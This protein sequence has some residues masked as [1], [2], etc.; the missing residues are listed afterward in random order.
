MAHIQ[1]TD[2]KIQP[3][4]SYIHVD[5]A[6]RQ[7]D[8]TNHY[9]E[10]LYSLPPYALHF[11]NNSS[12]VT[13][14][15]PGH[16]FKNGDHI[17]LNN[18]I[19]KNIILNNVLSVKK[20]SFFVRILHKNHG[21]SLHSLYNPNSS[22]E[23]DLIEY[24][25]ELPMS[26]EENDDIPDNLN[27]HYILKKNH[28]LD[29]TI[30][31]SN[32]IGSNFNR[33]FIGNISVNYLNKKQIVYLIFTKRNNIFQHDPDSYLIMLDKR[34]SINYK[35]GTNFLK[36]RSE[37]PTNILANNNIYIKFFNLFGIPLN[38]LNS[39]TPTNEN[40][41]YAYMTIVSTS[42]NSFTIDAN[43]NAIVDP[44]NSFYD[45]SDI[46]DQNININD[47]IGSNKGGGNKLFAR[48]IYITSSGY[49]DPNFYCFKLDRTYKNIFQIKMISSI[50]PNSQL[51]I[52]NKTSDIA[53]NKL[54]WRNLDDGDYIYSLSVQ[55]GNY[56]P[57]QLSNEIEKKFSKI[58]RYPYTKE[59]ESEIYQPFLDHLTPN[60]NMLYDEKGYNKFH[61]VKINI[62]EKTDKVLFRAFRELV[63][64]GQDGDVLNIPDNKI[65]ITVTDNLPTSANEILYMYI[66]P[67]THITS[68][69]AELPY[70]YNNLYKYI[71]Q[72]TRHDTFIADLDTDTAVLV[73]FYHT[74]D[75]NSEPVHELN[76]INTSSVLENFNYNYLDHLLGEVT[77]INHNLKNGDLVITDQFH[78]PGSINKI[79]VYE[80][81]EIVSADKFLVRRYDYGEKYKFIYGGTI[82]NFIKKDTPIPIP[83]PMLVSI[84]PTGAKKIMVVKHPNHQL[85]ENDVIT[86]SNSS[87]MNRVPAHIINKSYPINK[88]LD[89]N[90]YEILL[91]TYTPLENFVKKHTNMCNKISIK[92]PDKFQLL[93]NYGDTLGNIIGFSSVGENSSVTP[94]KHKIYNSDPYVSG[95]QEKNKLTK[96]NMTGYNYFYISCPELELYHNTKPV[97]NVFSVVRWFD[98]PGNVV[99][100]SFEPSTKIFRTP[101][102]F[103]FELN[104]AFYH[105][106]GRL[107][108]FNGLDHS[109]TLEI[110]E[111]YPIN[112]S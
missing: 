14:N 16:K 92:Y 110:T 8:H 22:E 70:T 19:S 72:R 90:H 10:E 15:L 4:I 67:D 87:P 17:I 79:S 9:E 89:Q 54:Y 45:Y 100:D 101:L 93:F 3:C 84:N 29:F 21:L 105:P 59:Y 46:L 52:N 61:I 69:D 102:S 97:K 32:I 96:L 111:L 95:V 86:I 55:P 77:K 39:G 103:L 106:D 51:T 2:Y 65:Q 28:K 6:Q 99:F 23:F 64:D 37:N 57:Q 7:K 41:K 26:Y 82:I 5:S 11:T 25:D 60:D 112:I 98:N 75:P 88:I 36:D 108:E 20:N 83:I 30:Q 63:Q 68:Q 33:N 80:I 44:T 62:S 76:S 40:F 42:D 73:N 35:D 38:Y 43:H 104:F 53:N 78:S 94:Y 31:L 50:F 58:I 49:P 81:N 18:V 34:S 27:Q 48:R 47:L 13:V 1:P 74:I 71:S 56:T 91:D 107:V 85:N 109:F 12:F 24:V 66:T